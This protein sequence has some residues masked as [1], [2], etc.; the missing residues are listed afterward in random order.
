[1]KAIKIPDTVNDKDWAPVWRELVENGG[2]TR[3]ALTEDSKARVYLVQDRQL[4]ILRQK[5]F[6]FEE[7]DYQK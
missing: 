1:M 7:V 6:P 5:N 2:L 3:I 4:K